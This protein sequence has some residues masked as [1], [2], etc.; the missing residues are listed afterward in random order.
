MKQLKSAGHIKL[1]N[2][3]QRWIAFLKN[4]YNKN[5]I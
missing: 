5:F 1:T 3:N 2:N 4:N